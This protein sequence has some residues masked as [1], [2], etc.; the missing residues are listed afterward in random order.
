M[1]LIKSISLILNERNQNG[2][3]SKF[4]CLKHTSPPSQYTARTAV[5]QEA[6]LNLGIMSSLYYIRHRAITKHVIRSLHCSRCA[7]KPPTIGKLRVKSW[8]AFLSH[9]TQVLKVLLVRLKRYPSIFKSS[10]ES[11]E[12]R[13]CCTES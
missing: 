5:Y 10:S 9:L 2:K 12:V 11:D 4:R 7:I 3:G 6:E 13:S 8:N 1:C